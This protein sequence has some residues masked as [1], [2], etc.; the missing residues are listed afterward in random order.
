MSVST[1]ITRMTKIER[2]HS[3]CKMCKAVIS[4]KKSFVYNSMASYLT[5][6]SDLIIC[7]AC[8]KREHGTKNKYK[9]ETLINDLEKRGKNEL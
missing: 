3:R 2:E 9:W 4:L 7:E 6:D 8:A 5:G 1:P